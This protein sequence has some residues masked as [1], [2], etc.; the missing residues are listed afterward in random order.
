M[1]W[2]LRR[3]LK[4]A[5]ELVGV[6]DRTGWRFQLRTDE[7][8]LLGLLS[9][10]DAEGLEACHASPWFRS[11]HEALDQLETSYPYW[12]SLHPDHVESAFRARVV[13]AFLR[14]GTT[15]RDVL[16]HLQD[17]LRRWAT[18]LLPASAHRFGANPGRTLGEHPTKGGPVVAKK[19]RWGPY[20]T[21]DRIYAAIPADKTPDTLTLEEAVSLLDAARAK[22][23]SSRGRG[24]RSS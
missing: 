4:A 23:G 16:N 24:P 21:H 1:S 2:I 11:W 22:L 3:S 8:T 7:G 10:E 5:L 9:D 6:E 13:G 20:V 14:H 15:E 12:R 17:I 18:A 19:G